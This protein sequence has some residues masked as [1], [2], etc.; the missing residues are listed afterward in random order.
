MESQVTGEY[1]QCSQS[2]EN[3]T[4]LGSLFGEAAGLGTRRF[5]SMA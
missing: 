2:S 4:V 1:F 3:K 5:T